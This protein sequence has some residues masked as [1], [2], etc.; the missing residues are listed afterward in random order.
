MLSKEQLLKRTNETIS[1]GREISEMWVSTPYQR[2]IDRQI[3]TVEQSVE[4]ED[5]G[6]VRNLVTD[7]AE[8]LAKAEDDYEV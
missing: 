2:D 6:K 4:H 1:W 7:L 8:Y 3:E 5:W